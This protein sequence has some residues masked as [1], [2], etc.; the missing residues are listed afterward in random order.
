MKDKKQIKIHLRRW[1]ESDLSL[2][3]RLMGDPAMTKHIGGP[4]TPEKIKDRLKKYCLDSATSGIHMFVIVL[5]PE[6]TAIGSIGFWEKTWQGQP[7]WESGWR[8]VPEYQGYGIATM[9]I[10][11]VIDRARAKNTRRYLHA[12]PSTDNA[13]SNAICRKTGFVLQKEVD[14]EYPPGRFMRSNDWRFD[15]FADGGFQ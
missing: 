5:E 8:I 14:F 7:V 13:P 4:E 9:A 10:M 11:Q 3:E 15:L 2:L 12:F 1:E 6:E